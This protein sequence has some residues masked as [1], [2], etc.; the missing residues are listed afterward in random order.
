MW[1][2][3]VCVPIYNTDVRPLV[4]ELCAQIDKIQE[5]AIDIILIDDASELRVKEINQFE[6]PKV[7]LISLEKNVGRAKI[8]NLFLTHAPSD[9]LLF[10]DGDST[11]QSPMFIENYKLYLDQ[12]PETQVL[13]GASR[14][15][16]A[17]PPINKRLRWRYSSKRESLPFS[18]RK[19]NPQHSFK[20]NNFLVRREILEQFPF[21]ERLHG[22]GHEDTLFGLQL[23]QNGLQVRH[24]DNPVWNLNLDSNAVFLEKTDNA[25]GNLLWI[26]R[27]HDS[28][29]LLQTNKLLAVYLQ[30]K[31]RI[32][33]HFLLSI[34]VGF[35]PMIKRFLLTGRAPLF[36]FDLYRLARLRKLDKNSSD[37]SF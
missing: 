15:Q 28:T 5:A 19:E 10:L 11:I 30:L 29:L 2:L 37:S 8:R 4:A 6:H 12:F 33:L 32:F 17:A 18:S 34:L 1:T 23:I 14:Y 36:C 9:F 20:T 16:V 13:V 26:Y 27:Y 31:S 21:D 22:Y 7:Q 3:S 25:L 35:E 24:I